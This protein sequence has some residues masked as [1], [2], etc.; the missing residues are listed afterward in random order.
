MFNFVGILLISIVKMKILSLR[1]F[2]LHMCIGE[3]VTQV[4]VKGPQFA[5]DTDS[6]LLCMEVVTSCR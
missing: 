3:E 2:Y 4:V 1:S 5:R 6:L